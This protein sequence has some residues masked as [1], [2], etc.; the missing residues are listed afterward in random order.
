MY[1]NCE[2]QIFTNVGGLTFNSK[3]DSGNLLKAEEFKDSTGKAV[4]NTWLLYIA[5]DN[6][7]TC[8]L[9]MLLWVNSS[10]G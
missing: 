7:G 6:E 3:F 9:W 1:V 8:V 5:A 4:A 2:Y 10:G